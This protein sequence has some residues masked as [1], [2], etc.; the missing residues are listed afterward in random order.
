VLQSHF[1][2]KGKNVVPH[3]KGTGTQQ[4]YIILSATTIGFKGNF[5]ILVGVK[6]KINHTVFG[7]A[8]K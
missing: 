6:D 3:G 2:N 7:L 1:T 4:G 8:T 5:K